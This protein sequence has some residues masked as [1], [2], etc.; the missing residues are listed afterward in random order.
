MPPGDDP[1]RKKLIAYIDKPVWEAT[2]RRARYEDRSAT[3][4]VRK[5]LR[6]YLESTGDLGADE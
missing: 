1:A 3:S 5:A 2:Q 6:L 4:V